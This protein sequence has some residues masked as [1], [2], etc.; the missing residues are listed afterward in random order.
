MKKGTHFVLV[1]ATQAINDN[2]GHARTFRPVCEADTHTHRHKQDKNMN[3]AHNH[4][5][6]KRLTPYS[7]HNLK[8]KKT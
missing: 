4:N 5:E 1:K 2:K 3:N 7:A 6:T 8:K